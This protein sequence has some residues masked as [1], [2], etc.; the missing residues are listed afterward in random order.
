MERKY[1]E[2]LMQLIKAAAKTA[3]TNLINE[4]PEMYSYFTVITPRECSSIYVSAVSRQARYRVAKESNFKRT[5]DDLAWSWDE[6]LYKAY[7]YD[8]P[9]FQE[10]K[11][12]LEM[13]AAAVAGADDNGK[14]EERIERLNSMIEAMHQL[15]EEGFWGT[16]E[17]RV[18]IVINAEI[19]GYTESSAINA[20]I[21]NASSEQLGYYLEWLKEK[22]AYIIAEPIVKEVVDHFSKKEYASLSNLA[23]GE[24][25]VDELEKFMEGYLELNNLSGFDPFGAEC[26]DRPD[27]HDYRQ[28]RCFV[29]S[30]N[31]GFDVD[32][33]LAAEGELCPFTLEMEFIKIDDSTYKPIIKRLNV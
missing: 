29:Y 10:L 18:R 2:K 4:Y 25:G 23:V 31:T 22:Q 3:F 5:I 13:H 33:D 6:S 21:L 12:E 11:D 26:I 17:D 16:G 8:E 27:R 14:E 19:E 30:D 1:D 24:W 15:D 32:Y 7:Q 28:L 9:Y 20:K